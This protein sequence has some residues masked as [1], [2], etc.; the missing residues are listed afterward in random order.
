[1]GEISSFDE[2]LGHRHGT[3]HSGK[4]FGGKWKKDPGHLYLWLHTK[5][6]PFS[7]WTH[8]FPKLWSSDKDGSAKKGWLM[9][10]M[11]CWEDES[12]L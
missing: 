7:I 8:P 9:A 10:D 2:F 6:L 1:M 12:V 11:V 3:N 4:R 5:Q